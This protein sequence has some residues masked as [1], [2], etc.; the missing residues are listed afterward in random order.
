MTIK[1]AARQLN[2]RLRSIYD[3]GES[4]AIADLVI[5]HLTAT[6]RNSQVFH[7]EKNLSTAQEQQ[8]KHYTERLLRHEPV[9][10]VL[11]EAWFCGF[12]FYV[13]KNVLV[14]RP[15]TEELVD[16]V[17]SD[18]R[19]PVDRLSILDIGTGSG[20]IPITLK[21]KLRK[22]EVVGCD[23]S[24]A[25]LDVA[26][27]NASSLGA[28][29]KFVLLDFLDRGKRERLASFDIIT[30]NPPYVPAKDKAQ[31]PRN[32]VDYEPPGALFVPDDDALVF[33]KAIA[34][35]GKNH[36]NPGGIVYAEIHEHLSQ[37]VSLHFRSI[38]YNVLVK[39]DMQGKERMI[40][41]FH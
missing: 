27:K 40:K 15:E 32:V 22:A 41:A 38:G 11:N 28:D 7:Q 17:I 39:K 4:G 12:R 23:I 33:Y 20:C 30:S 6:A 18:C 25:A 29:V 8:L 37:Q 16:W 34:E 3:E 24:E 1:E 31:M 26:R 2:D 5:E 14:P 35:F 9:Q 21:R 19:F 36:L 10:Y 13:D